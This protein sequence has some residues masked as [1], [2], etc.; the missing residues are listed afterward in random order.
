[1]DINTVEP[2]DALNKAIEDADEKVKIATSLS[3]MRS[4]EGWQIL[5]ETFEE[6]KRNQLRE[7]ANQSPGD[8]KAVLAAHAVWSA[9]VHTLNQVVNA[10]NMAV[11]E[12][13]EA[14]EFLEALKHTPKEDDWS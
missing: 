9:T 6:M 8:E 10:V 5:L 7:L 12:G 4:T 3:I 11:Q 13:I 14:Q 2:Q 1:M